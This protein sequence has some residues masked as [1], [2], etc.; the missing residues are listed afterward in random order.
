[1]GVF[2][3]MELDTQPIL[4][5]T[6]DWKT[7][8]REKLA[9]TESYGPNRR[10]DSWWWRPIERASDW[11][12]RFHAYPF[13]EKLIV[14]GTAVLLVALTPMALVSLIG[15]DDGQTEASAL[16]PTP[17]LFVIPTEPPPTDTPAP[18]PTVPEPTP[19]A[20][21]T[22][23][24]A[25]TRQPDRTSCAAI[26]AS[27]YR[28]SQERNW[29]LA[30]CIAAD[31]ATATPPPP[32]A[33]QPPSTFYSAGEAAG[34]VAG[35][36]ARHPSLSELTILPGSCSARMVSAGQWRVSCQAETTGCVGTACVITITACLTDDQYA[37]I[38]LC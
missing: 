6:M 27:S 3:L 26:A 8:R 21:A 15:G 22:A 1:M 25:A 35:W 23:E 16:L 33:T 4:P 34:L 28:S 9:K 37:D 36:I 5:L 17:T 29:Y 32:N 12:E 7:L 31:L 2:N 38:W 10:R 18:T 11:W 30:N 24:P 20:T 13:W 19:T 14:A